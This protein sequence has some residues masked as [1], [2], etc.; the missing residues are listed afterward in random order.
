V[1]RERERS[2]QKKI[3]RANGPKDCTRIYLILSEGHQASFPYHAPQ[4]LR[5]VFWLTDRPTLRPSRH[6]YQWL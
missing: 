6:R 2:L 3:L 5:Q 4:A 1:V